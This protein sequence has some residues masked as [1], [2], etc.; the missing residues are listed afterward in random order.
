MKCKLCSLE[1][2]LCDS[3]IIPETFWKTINDKKFRSLPISSH[4]IKLKFVQNGIKEKLLCQDCETKLS[5]WESI[6]A[7]D[8]NDIGKR[9][10]RF[11]K[12]TEP[13]ENMIFIENLRY[14]KFKLA[15]LS[16]LWRFSVSS[17]ELFQSYKL[18]KYEEK[19]RLLLNSETCP[20][21]NKYAIMLSQYKIGGVFHSD[22]I[23]GFPPGKFEN[24]YIIQKFI[25]WGHMFLFVV[26][27]KSCPNIPKECFLRNNGSAYLIVCDSSELVS[28]TSVLSR[29]YDED[30]NKM[31]GKLN[32]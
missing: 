13:K 1:K 5:A 15:A 8:L 25:I 19:I 29:I 24:K 21:E 18:G 12:I 26:N 17:N 9:K 23:L 30:V 22:I 11:L 28:G 16:I 10:S 32:T 3:H 20:P 4:P 14:E 6:L 7:N 31:M 2:K 27:D